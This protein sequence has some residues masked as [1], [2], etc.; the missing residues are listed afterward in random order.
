MVRQLVMESLMFAGTG[1]V[2]GV[3]LSYLV[4][5]LMRTELAR[6]VP[7]LDQIAINE[8]A[9]GLGALL[10]AVS[11][12]I[13]GLVPALRSIRANLPSSAHRG[14]AHTLRMRQAL[15][16]SQVAFAVI[17]AVAAMA[18]VRSF[19]KLAGVDPGFNPQNALAMDLTFSKAKY[20]T[21]QRQTAFLRNLLEQVRSLPGVAAAG[22]VSDLPLRRNS[23]TF[24]VLRPEEGELPKDKLPQAGVR[25]LT[26]DYFSAMLISLA[27]GRF[28]D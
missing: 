14:P 22:A 19:V 13:C 23:M 27:R 2:V 3:L 20:P 25:W 11:M 28:L 6:I 15:V 5:A 18:V 17:L 12:V 7:V 8:A 21:S 10:V 9:L 4:V 26:A 16:I 1:G 24:R